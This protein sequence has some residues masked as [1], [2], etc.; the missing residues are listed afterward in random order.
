MRNDDL[1]VDVL[2]AACILL[3]VFW[4]FLKFENLEMEIERLSQAYCDAT[5]TVHSCTSALPSIAVLP[6]KGASPETFY[7]WVS[8]AGHKDVDAWAWKVRPARMTVEDPDTPD[9]GSDTNNAPPLSMGDIFSMPH[10]VQNPRQ[11]PDHDGR[12]ELPLASL[13][14]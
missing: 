8:E 14:M 11:I 10:E 7:L 3:T 5:Q 4:N 2:L 13:C 1:V 12:R 6:G 9:R